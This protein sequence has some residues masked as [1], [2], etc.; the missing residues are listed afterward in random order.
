MKKLEFLAVV[1]GVSLAVGGGSYG[2]YR[3]SEYYGN[4]ANLTNQERFYQDMAFINIGAI[5]GCGLFSEFYKLNK[6][7]KK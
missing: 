1:A 3:V 2:G 4:K 7:R 6:P 5:L